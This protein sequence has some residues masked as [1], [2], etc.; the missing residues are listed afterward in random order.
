VEGFEGDFL[1]YLEICAIPSQQ[2]VGSTTKIMEKNS[3]L[4]DAVY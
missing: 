2:F 1:A 3:P 4:S